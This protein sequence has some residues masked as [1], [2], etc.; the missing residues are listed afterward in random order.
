MTG[1]DIATIM[2]FGVIIFLLGV[3]LGSTF[4]KDTTESDTIKC[5]SFIGTTFQE[6]CE[7]YNESFGKMT[8]TNL[9]LRYID[10]NKTEVE[11]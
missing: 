7:Q 1:K 6:I 10:F 9:T 2:L 4:E 8:I 11:K 5:N 3:L